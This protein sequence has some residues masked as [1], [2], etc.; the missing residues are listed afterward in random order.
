MSVKDIHESLRQSGFSV[1]APATRIDASVAI[2]AHGIDPDAGPNYAEGLATAL[3]EDL[4]RAFNDAHLSPTGR[5]AFVL[6]VSFVLDV[7]TY[8]GGSFAID[9]SVIDTASGS[10]FLLP[11]RVST[12]TGIERGVA[13]GWPQYREVVALVYSDL[14]N[15]FSAIEAIDAKVKDALEK[16]KV[17]EAHGNLKTALNIYTDALQQMVEQQTGTSLELTKHAV[18]VAL[19]V[20]P[21]E[22]VPNSA[23]AYVA[24]AVAKI[25]S[26]KTKDDLLSARTEY[27]KALALAPWWSDGWFNLALINQQLGASTLAARNLELYLRAAPNAEDR[28][29]VEGKI[30]ALDGAEK[31]AGEQ[32]VGKW[33]WTSK[34]NG[35]EGTYEI[36][37][38]SVKDGGVVITGGSWNGSFRGGRIDGKT[39][40]FWWG[41]A[42]NAA[43]YTGTIS[44]AS[45][46]GGTYVQ[47]ILPG[48]CLWSA[49]KL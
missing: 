14:Q 17:A 41:N 4:A 5:E 47:S 25:K 43:T 28:R 3:S 35:G 45:S 10:R 7:G 19:K 44:S 9:G 15:I 26:A 2:E 16:G 39:I 18:D 40:K 36:T 11:K 38:E 23:I 37:I 49:R 33:A 31:H 46:M 48:T 8:R 30:A 20:R 1:P 42:L 22:A 21:R 32:L 27:M 12:K 24:A 6:D 29:I 13:V 34:C